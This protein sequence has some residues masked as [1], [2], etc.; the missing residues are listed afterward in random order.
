MSQWETL[1]FWVTVGCY[2]TATFFYLYWFITGRTTGE[3]IE[4]VIIWAGFLSNL[5]VIVARTLT[6][7]HLPVRTL[8]ELNIVV[9]WLAVGVFL[10][11]RRTYTKTVLVGLVSVTFAFL[12]AGW[13]YAD[14][15]Q[16]AP[17][18]PAYKSNWLVVHVLFALLSTACY[19]F[20]TGTSFFYLLKSRY[21]EGE[22]PKRYK[23]V[24]GLKILDDLSVKLILLGFVAG[25]IMLISG[26]IWAKLL[27][28]SYWSW[29]PV[30][31]WSLISWLV[32]GIYL[33]LRFTFGWRGRKL[34]WLCM[35][36]LITNVISSW[37]VGVFT[38]ETYHSYEGISRPLE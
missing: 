18:T 34:A 29:D 26:S 17:L 37:A 13:G 31:T 4:K 9:A 23:L 19:I 35:A 33:H 3:K 8:Y 15:P 6:S 36:C 38:P 28:G 32:Y 24:P 25:T 27:W 11:A 7:G 30:E 16:I 5:E 1:F 21:P 22:G 10:W 20:A 12:V 2:V 14:N